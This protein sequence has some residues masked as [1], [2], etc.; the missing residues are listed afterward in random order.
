MILHRLVRN[1]SILDKN[2]RLHKLQPNWAQTRYLDIATEQLQ[3]TGRIRIIV[4]KAR[5]LGISTISEAVL[6]NLTQLFDGYRGLVV[7]HEVPASQNL[8][9][10]TH[11]YWDTYPFRRLFTTKNLSKN[12]IAWVERGSSIKVATA[13]NKAVGR[14]ATI[15]GL[16]ASELAFWPEPSTAMLGLRQTIPTT[17]GTM[18]VL[19]STANGI[20]DYFHQQWTLAE[21]GETEY[22]PLFLP[23]QDHPEYTAAAIN[24]PYA[25][26]GRLDAE[27]KV[28]ANLGINEDRLAW[29]RWAIK[30]LCES[31]P[32]KFMQEYPA[33]PEEAFIA[34][35]SN[36]FPAERL[37]DI[38]QPINGYTGLLLR[39]GHSIEFKPASNGP[40]T[41]YK[42]PTP[43]RDAGRYIVAGDPTHS[44]RGDYACAQV[45][46]RRTME[47]VAVWR[48]RIDPTTFGEELFKLGLYYNDALLTTEIEG[49]GYATVGKL[50]GM[51]YPN[52]Y[53]KARADS[54]PGK[55]AGEQYGWSTTVQS[56]HLAVNWLLK[57][58]MDGSITVHDR[59]TY[60]EMRNYV[61]LENGGYGN[62][63]E[64][65]HDDTVM[66]L[67]IGVTCHILDGPMMPYGAEPAD[68]I[69][70][71]L[72]PNLWH[73][74][75]DE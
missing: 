29:R 75:D 26:L 22:T 41:V 46:N 54:T 15:H 13:G 69:P 36:V 65:A 2:L 44:T 52:I 60:D 21:E 17:P 33:T 32:L 49:P 3:T 31:D 18:I 72:D 55:F 64:E 70:G 19:E 16:H 9:N 11:R 42:A 8:L 28:L 58:V 6:F 63:I 47:Q 20:G 40:L 24:L 10:M 43:D 62:A 4:L 37:R 67:A 38:Y 30:N 71:S 53:R 56:K 66:A 50:L 1:L 61:T 74:E 59:K 7:A 23:W 48:G 5:Q 45:I 73:L 34:S 12:E 14:S 57:C 27:E 51:E 39:D 68:T 35:G 25:P